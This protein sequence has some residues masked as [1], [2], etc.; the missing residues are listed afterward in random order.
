MWMVF[1]GHM[2]R[3]CFIR[4]ATSSFSLRESTAAVRSARH[5]PV[6]F[7]N[8]RGA[9]GWKLGDFRCILDEFWMDLGIPSGH[10]L[11]NLLNPVLGKLTL[12]VTWWHLHLLWHRTSHA[13]GAATHCGT[14]VHMG[15]GRCQHKDLVTVLALAG[16]THQS[17][18]CLMFLEIWYHIGIYRYTDIHIHI[19]IYMYVFFYIYIYTYVFICNYIYIYDRETFRYHF[20]PVNSDNFKSLLDNWEDLKN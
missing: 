17:H 13:P 5:Q 20:V 1:F 16:Q 11:L 14:G 10:L 8:T 6:L 9:I 18:R 12:Q 4:A 3:P 19:Y 15:D 7:C 2:H